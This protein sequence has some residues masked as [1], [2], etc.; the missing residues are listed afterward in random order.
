MTARRA[1]VFHHREFPFPRVLFQEAFA[2]IRQ[3]TDNVKLS[4]KDRLVRHHGADF[5]AV[6][7]IDQ[8]RFNDVVPMVGKRD[9]VAAFFIR[10]FKFFCGAGG[11][12]GS[13]DFS[14]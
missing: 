11:N 2:Q 9:F 12:R 10:N 3:G 1:G 5:P 6:K 13:R 4:A 7:Q 14:G 8:K